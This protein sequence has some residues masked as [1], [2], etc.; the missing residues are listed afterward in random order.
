MKK[1]MPIAKKNDSRGANASTSSP[2]ACA[3]RHIFH[4]V[5]EREGQLLQL[6]GPR[7]LHVI[8]ADR[9]RVEP[10][11]MFGGEGDDVGDDPHAR[12]GRVD[13]GVADH[14]LLQ[15]VVLDRPLEQRRG[16]PLLLGGDDVEGEARDHRAVHR[17]ADRHLVKRDAV[18]QDLHVLD[19][20]DRDAGL[21]DVAGD[22]RMVAVVAAVGGEV[23]G[24][25]QPL[26]PGGEVA[27]VEF[28]RRLGRREARVLADR[29]R[30]PGV[31]R[32]LDPAGERREPGQAG[33]EVGGV[34]L[35][36][37]RLD[38]DPLGRVPVEVAPLGLPGR[39]LRPVVG[40][41]HAAPLLALRS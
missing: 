11:H 22:A 17:H 19:R 2:R 30:P 10:R 20:I 8:A 16:D 13:I 15:D 9:D 31:H 5:G 38:D 32:R 25:R 23:E 34:G 18:E 37:E 26:L 24:D 33:V 27:A 6:R 41:R 35:R 7:L 3:A 14:E 40:G 28:V 12:F 39:Q 36:V 4:A 29:P 21:T 1:F